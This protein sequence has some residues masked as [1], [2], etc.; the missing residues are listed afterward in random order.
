MESKIDLRIP[1]GEIKNAIAVAISESFTGEKKD[2]LIRDVIR[3]HLSVKTD[4]WGRETIIDKC[5]GNLIR[6]IAE[7]ELVKVLE[8]MRPKIKKSIAQYLGVGF[9]DSLCEQIEK[10]LKNT[11]VYGFKIS[12]DTI[13]SCDES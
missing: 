12:V 8:E 5:V 13:K 6:T 7:E 9:S 2:A 1:E 3:G 11:I 4:T 10:A